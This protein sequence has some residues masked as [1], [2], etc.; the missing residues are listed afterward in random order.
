MAPEVTGQRLLV[1]SSK[2]KL[3]SFTG[4]AILTTDYE[5][6]GNLASISAAVRG[7]V[8]AGARRISMAGTSIDTRS[9]CRA[10]STGGGAE[11]I[12]K[13]RTIIKQSGTNDKRELY[14]RNCQPQAAAADRFPQIYE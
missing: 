11:A 2:E 5:V 12:R 8:C 9:G 14:P 1:S 4:Y 3:E 10:P 7:L 6:W 13:H